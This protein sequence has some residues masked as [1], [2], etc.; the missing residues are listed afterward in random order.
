MRAQ[1]RKADFQ[2]V[3]LA[4]AGV[5]HRA[6]APLAMRIDDIVDE[7]V[8][9]SPRQRLEHQPTLPVAIARRIPVLQRA[10]PAGAEMRTDWRNALR[11]RHIDANEATTIRMAGPGINI[12][13]LARKC[14]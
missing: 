12:G 4:A 6:T 11:A 7:R 1:R 14:I 5:K 9:S 8:N 13:G 3:A 10:A 2:N